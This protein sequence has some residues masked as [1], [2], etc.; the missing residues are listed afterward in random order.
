MVGTSLRTLIRIELGQPGPLIGVDQIYNVIVTDHAF[1]IIFFIV[2][3]IIIGGFRNLLV[4]LIPGAPDMAFP[5][6]SNISF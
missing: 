2:M 1:F 5:R 3:P 4:P 6:I